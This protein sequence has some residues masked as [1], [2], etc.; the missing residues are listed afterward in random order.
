MSFLLN[1]NAFILLG[2]TSTLALAGEWVD[3][4]TF[5]QENAHNRMRLEQKTV[6]FAIPEEAIRTSSNLTFEFSSIDN[7]PLDGVNF[8]GADGTRMDFRGMQGSVV[9]PAS[10][11]RANSAYQFT[12]NVNP[13]RL[14]EINWKTGGQVAEPPKAQT[15]PEGASVTAQVNLPVGNATLTVNLNG[16]REDRREDRREAREERREDRREDRRDE[17]R[18]RREERRDDRDDRGQSLTS[19]DNDEFER[20]GRFTTLERDNS[21]SSVNLDR[22]KNYFEIPHKALK[23]NWKWNRI[24]LQIS[25]E[26]NQPLDGIVF[27]VDNG[28]RTVLNGYS[29]QVQISD[30]GKGNKAVFFIRSDS[31]RKIRINWWMSN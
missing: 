18:E 19:S 25:A 4:W 22:G 10:A 12:V 3:R 29:Q 30:P 1:R 16:G 31:N 6:I 2:L 27:R 17:R 7:K 23:R 21:E 14:V 9:V 11:V 13:T 28:D 5:H 8:I 20:D 15:K 24:S 26:D